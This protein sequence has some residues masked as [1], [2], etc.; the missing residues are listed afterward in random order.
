[1]LQ[2]RP[3]GNPSER[4]RLVYTPLFPLTRWPLNPRMTVYRHCYTSLYLQQFNAER[5]L[6]RLLDLM[7]R[8][9]ARLLV[10]ERTCVLPW[11]RSTDEL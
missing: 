10:A 11:G 3:L 8:G 9:V 7:A 1:M 6:P 2:A 4:S 5:D